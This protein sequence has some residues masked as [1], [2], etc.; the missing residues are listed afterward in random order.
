MLSL[1][2]LLLY[3]NLLVAVLVAAQLSRSF[4][5]VEELLA[6]PRSLVASGT[7]HLGILLI[8]Y[9]CCDALLNAATAL[10]CFY[11]DSIQS[12]ADI[13]AGLRRLTAVAA[14]LVVCFPAHAQVD[15]KS[16]DDSIDRTLQQ[17]EFTWRMPPR[18]EEAPPLVNWF[19][20]ALEWSYDLLDK[21][22]SAIREWLKPR[23]KGA[24]V[25]S[26][27]GMPSSVRYLL[28]A[29]AVLATAAIVVVY[30]RA[31]RARTT[32][33]EPSSA[34]T[35]R[36]IDVKD[37]SV[38][39]DQLSED[40][41]LEMADGLMAKGEYRLALRAMHLAGLRLL[42]ERRLVTIQRWKSGLE[43]HAEIRRRARQAP[44]L[45]EAFARNL[46]L[47]D[48]GWYSFHPVEPPMLDDYRHRLKEIRAYA[49]Q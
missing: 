39:A 36:S 15:R 28:I 46:R 9:S 20:K 22:F 8:V 3:V 24:G 14:L 41:W 1:V 43:Y 7:I 23:D 47:F 40:S 2:A 11:G 13:L 30:V 27:S 29:L 44:Q 17:R 49:A 35:V 21:V 34:A 12:G 33:I 32:N 19:V 10:R 4:F 38:L 25:D 31:M 42:A 26:G 37:E 5:G 48:L 16:L 45:G 18:D 6:D